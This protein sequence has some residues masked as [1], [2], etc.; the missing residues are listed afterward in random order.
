[1]EL[2]SDV[3]TASKRAGPFHLKA[4]ARPFLPLGSA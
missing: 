3:A 1:L 2:K 4:P